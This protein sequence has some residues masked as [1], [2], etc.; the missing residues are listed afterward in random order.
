MVDANLFF[1]NEEDP[2]NSTLYLQVSL[3]IPACRSTIIIAII[4]ITKSRYSESTEQGYD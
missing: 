3:K 1:D 2:T 4:I